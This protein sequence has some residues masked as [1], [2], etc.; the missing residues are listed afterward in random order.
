MQ[1]VAA[2]IWNFLN[3]DSGTAISTPPRPMRS[4]GVGGSVC[5]FPKV[6]P[7]AISD[8]WKARFHPITGHRWCWIECPLVAR[9]G[10]N[11]RA[12]DASRGLPYG[13]IQS[14]GAGQGGV[15]QGLGQA[16]TEDIRYSEDR[17]LISGSDMDRAMPRADDLSA[18]RFA[19]LPVPTTTDPPG[20]KGCGEAGCTA[21]LPPVLERAL[22]EHDT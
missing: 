2:L 3:P 20:A 10:P 8:R 13:R 15:T 11:R 7:A 16:L 21:A 9:S 17:Q 12:A 4:G 1:S 19:P 5:E 14:R 6:S 22:R 18:V